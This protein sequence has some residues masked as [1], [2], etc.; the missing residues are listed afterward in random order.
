MKFKLI[1]IHYI[2]ELLYGMFALTRTI[3]KRSLFPKTS[4][5]LTPK[6][7]Y[8]EKLQENQQN[9]LNISDL[10]NQNKQLIEEMNSL[11]VLV[12]KQ[13]ELIKNPEP[14]IADSFICMII[15]LMA[16]GV[17]GPIVWDIIEWFFRTIHESINSVFDSIKIKQ[18]AE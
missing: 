15:G 8:C 17:F 13:T 7:L 4:N 12:N 2:S 18:I 9:Q 5:V 1:D 10:I 3:T 11:K 16:L 14:G 6:R